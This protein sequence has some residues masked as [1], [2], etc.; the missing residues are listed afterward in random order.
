M[1]VLGKYADTPPLQIG[2]YTILFLTGILLMAGTVE[3]S[4]LTEETY[5]YGVNYTDYHF[6]DYGT[7]SS[8][9]INNN[10]SVFHKNITKIYQPV[11]EEEIIAGIKVRHTTGFLLAVL[12]VFG[13]LSVMTNLDRPVFG[14][15]EE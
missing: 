8:P 12:S 10:P 2:G 15:K 9:S 6:D 4:I 11:A 14:R 13:F 5:I 3:H 1:V 7:P